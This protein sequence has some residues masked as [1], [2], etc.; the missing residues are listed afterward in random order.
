M[1]PS[2]DFSDHSRDTKPL[3]LQLEVGAPLQLIH[4]FFLGEYQSI[5]LNL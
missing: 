2:A 3:V 5:F 1:S 4:A